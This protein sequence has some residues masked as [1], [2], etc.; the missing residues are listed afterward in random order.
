MPRGAKQYTVTMSDETTTRVVAF[1]ER[2]A[3]TRVQ[4]WLESKGS[5]AKVTAINEVS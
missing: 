4:R 1:T 5:D 2:K 3:I